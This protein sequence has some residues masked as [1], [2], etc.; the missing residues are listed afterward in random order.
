MCQ[1]HTLHVC[2]RVRRDDEMIRETKKNDKKR[3]EFK[4]KKKE[5]E[6]QKNDRTSKQL[7]KTSLK[8]VIKD[9]APFNNRY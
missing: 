2:M 4:K 5:G 1:A 6:L 3:R 9:I 8:I 7:F